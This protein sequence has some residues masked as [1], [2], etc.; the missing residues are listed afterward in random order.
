MQFLLYIIN[1]RN[2]TAGI[3]VQSFQDDGFRDK[4]LLQI[5]EK[6][7]QIRKLHEFPSITNA[8]F[9]YDATYHI[10]QGRDFPLAQFRVRSH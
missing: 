2:L 6:E 10:K 4:V 9:L 5:F 7:F 1:I 3:F 8:L